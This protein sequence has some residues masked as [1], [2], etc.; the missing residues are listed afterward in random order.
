MSETKFS[1]FKSEDGST[2][3]DLV[4]I[5]SFTSPYYF[6][7]PSGTT[8][9]RPSNA[10]PGQLRFNTDIGRLEVWRGDH[11][12]TILGE[13]PSLNGGAR[14]VFGGGFVSPARIN[15]IEY[16]TISTI[17]NATDFGDLTVARY[18]CKWCASSTRGLAGG[19]NDTPIGGHNVIDYITISSTGNA[20]D[21]GDRIGA[22]TELAGAISNQTRGCF[23]GGFPTSGNVIDYV[24]ISSTGNAQDFGDLTVAR[25][26]SNGCSSPTRGLFFGGEIVAAPTFTNIIDYITISTIGSAFDFGDISSARRGLAA[27]SNATRGLAAGGDG[28]ANVNNIEYVTMTTLGNTTDFGDLTAARGQSFAGMSSSTRGVFGDS[29]PSG[30]IMDYVTITTTGNAID[31]G[32]A[33]VASANRGGTSNAHGGL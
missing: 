26:H 6:V 12:A 27:C 22:G 32:D 5:T 25:G 23:A 29:S 16:I 18:G 3:P 31:F 17:G 1:N 19:G 14:G 2:G 10:V 8:A 24:T 13:S 30:N 20:V 4:G 33:I 11:W 7:P 21:F 9:Q 15:N 28:P